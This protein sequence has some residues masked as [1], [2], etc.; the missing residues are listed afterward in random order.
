MVVLV[1]TCGTLEA[2]RKE[3]PEVEFI[4]KAGACFLV[5]KTD[6]DWWFGRCLIF[7]HIGNN[8]ANIV[9]IPS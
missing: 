1:G 3:M 8:I 2:P 6:T 4:T 7:P 5:S 9:P